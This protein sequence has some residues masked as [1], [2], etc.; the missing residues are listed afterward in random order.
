[1]VVG[2]WGVAGVPRALF[3]SFAGFK[4]AMDIADSPNIGVRGF[5]AV[6]PLGL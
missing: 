5:E 2:C 3:G 6:N 1:M 4:K